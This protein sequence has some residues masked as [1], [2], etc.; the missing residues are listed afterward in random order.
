MCY[1]I[2]SIFLPSCVLISTRVDQHFWSSIARLFTIGR[3]SR[4]DALAIKQLPGSL[5]MSVEH[6]TKYGLMVTLDERESVARALSNA[7]KYIMMLRSWSN[8]LM[9]RV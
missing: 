4:R 1:A 9:S 3:R 5:T 8:Q 6:L 2:I 7:E